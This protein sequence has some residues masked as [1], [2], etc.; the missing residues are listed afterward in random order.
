V[1]RPMI[2]SDSVSGT[3]RMVSSVALPPRENSRPTGI[4]RRILQG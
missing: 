1:P 2:R 3:L 4:K